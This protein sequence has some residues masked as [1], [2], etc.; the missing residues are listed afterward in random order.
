MESCALQIGHRNPGSMPSIRPFHRRSRLQFCHLRIWGAGPS[1][2]ILAEAS[3]GEFPPDL[4]RATIWGV[5]RGV[6]RFG[7][8]VGTRNRAKAPARPT[9]GML[10]EGAFDETATEF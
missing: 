10:S 7:F 9:A 6:Q 5:R 8:K 3:A 2:V 4:P 1:A